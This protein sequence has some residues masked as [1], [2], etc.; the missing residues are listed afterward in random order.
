MLIPLAAARAPTLIPYWAAIP[1]RVWPAATVTLL[2]AAGAAGAGR[3]RAGPRHLEDR[4]GV[5][6]VGIADPVGGG[7]GGHRGPQL[8]RHLGERLAGLDRHRPGG[9]HPGR[10]GQ[11]ESDGHQGGQRKTDGQGAAGPTKEGGGGGEVHGS[12]TLDGSQPNYVP[13]CA[14]SNHQTS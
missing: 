14:F 4:P 6:Q 13:L 11:A 9:G 12:G 3:C 10:E 5:D 7:Q 8:G 2:A 1:L